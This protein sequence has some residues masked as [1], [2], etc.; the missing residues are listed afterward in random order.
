LI[1]HSELRERVLDANLAIV[2]AGLVTLTFGNASGV[3]R[4]AGVMAIKPSGV[5]YDE[6]QPDSIVVVDL[7]SGEVVDGAFR[8]SSDTPTHLTLYRRFDA[9]GGVVHTHSASAT[10]WAQ[11]GRELACYG[12]THA[13]HFHGSVPV[14]R[15]LTPEEI[16]AD[17]EARTGDVIVETIEALE[18][19]PLDMPAVLVRS[20]G[21]FAWGSDEAEAVEN[22]IALEAVAS[23]AASS[24]ALAPE[25]QPI[26]PELLDRHFRRKHGAGAYYG[27]PR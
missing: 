8:P 22:A 1:T 15:G 23:M 12:T 5:S 17:Y 24:L 13:D 16:G 25:L 9:V 2:E 6:L 7:V 19:D 3:D 4:S 21:P 18:L 20:H 11:A 26:A 27:Q 14:T 10:A